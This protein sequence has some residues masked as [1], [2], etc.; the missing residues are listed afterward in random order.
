VSL[1]DVTPSI[2][3]MTVTAEERRSQP[4]SFAGR[5]LA[6]AMMEGESI[7]QRPMRYVA[8]A[9]KKGFAPNWLSWMWVHDPRLP[10]RVGLT[11]GPRKMIWSPGRPSL[12]LYNINSDPLELRPNVLRS[13]DAQYK[14]E[15]A[16]LRRWFQSTDLE[17]AEVKLSSRDAEVLKSLGYIQ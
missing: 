12:S 17:E 16:A 14:R 4:F 13:D 7:P 8:F 11:E 10:L 9:G 15:T 2:V 1:L 5:S 6:P 3:D